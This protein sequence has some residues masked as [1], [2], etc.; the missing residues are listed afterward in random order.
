MIKKAFLLLACLTIFIL[1]MFG[2]QSSSTKKIENTTHIVIGY[3]FN[4]YVAIIKEQKEIKQLVDLFNGAEFTKSDASIQQPYLSISFSE[5]KSST[6]FYIDDKDVIQLGDGNYMKSK[7]I[8]F[9][10]LYSIFY[11][12]SSKKK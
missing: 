8:N 4:S 12:Y 7:Q 11:E 3:G 2:C 10:K 6:L 5:K 9:N 1:T